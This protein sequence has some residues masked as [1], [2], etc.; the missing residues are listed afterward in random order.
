MIYSTLIVGYK[1]SL[2]LDWDIAQKILDQMVADERH[3]DLM[4]LTEAFM[5]EKMGRDQ[6]DRWLEEVAYGPDIEIVRDFTREWEEL[7]A[8]VV[9]E[10]LERLEDFFAHP[11]DY[12]A[13]RVSGRWAIRGPMIASTVDEQAA[14][15][16]TLLRLY[17]M[18]ITEALGISV[19]E[20]VA[21]VESA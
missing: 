17:R 8:E 4:E 12:G 15:H 18:G 1:G 19:R 3:E 2:P 9:S 7:F 13:V 10:D 14:L 20:T 5:E 11:A 6:Y 21:A 16:A